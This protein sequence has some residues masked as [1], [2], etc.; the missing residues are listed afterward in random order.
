[1]AINHADGTMFASVLAY[2]FAAGAG[3]A[4]AGAGWLAV[5]FV[6]AGL[7]IGIG[8]CYVGRT[9]IYSIMGMVL[10]HSAL[11]LQRQWL[12]NVVLVPFLVLYMVLPY[13]ITAG[14]L[15][16]TWAGSGWIVHAIG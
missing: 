13:T 6:P 3:A 15:W 5:L 2:P 7:A 16:L 8:A 12:Q 14:G 10:N 9:I 1:M 11:R 4:Q